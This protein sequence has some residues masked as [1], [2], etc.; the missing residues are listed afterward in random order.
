MKKFF[1]EVYDTFKEEGLIFV[2][3]LATCF[4]HNM[5]WG[6]IVYVGLLLIILI[7]VFFRPLK[8]LFDKTLIALLL[9]GVFYI[10]FSP[11]FDLVDALRVLLGPSLFYIYGRDTVIRSQNTSHIIRKVILLMIVAISFP[12][13]WAVIKNVLS[14]NLISISS[15]EGARW[16]T[17]W[18]QSH[19]AAA[20]TYGLIASF[21]LC[22]FGCFLMSKGKNSSLDP[23]AFLLC[24]VCSLLTT[25]YL[26][27]R[28]GIVIVGI[29]TFVAFMYGVRGITWKTFLPLLLFMVII[30]VFISKW[31]GT[32]LIAEAY[33]ERESVVLGGDRTWRWLDALKRLFTNPFGWS[34]EFQVG[35]I[36]VHNMWLDVARVAGIVPFF[37]LLFATF[38]SLKSNIA[39]FR[40]KGNE[41]SL[42]LLSLYSAVFSAYMIEPV[43]DA[44]IFYLMI[45]TWIWGIEKE[46]VVKNIHVHG[47]Y[48]RHS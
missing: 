20:T 18:G 37:T 15:E 27:N 4:T 46:V 34:D 16:L 3:F 42:L 43:I 36:Y 24:S 7:K 1:R 19:M 32:A 21:G 31:G 11:S 26:I 13:W 9:F 25:T 28:S 38:S 48:F 14:G 10:L 2:L 33:S 35:Y 30:V 29:V 45:F 23:W 12:V 44:N 8:R 47:L 40:V 41:L 17:T 22:G 39:L 6:S 5:D